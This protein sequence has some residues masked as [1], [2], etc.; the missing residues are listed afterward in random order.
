[1]TH[2]LT[3]ADFFSLHALGL[4]NSKAFSLG[5]FPKV[6]ICSQQAS[7]ILFPTSFKY[8]PFHFS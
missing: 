3:W 8:V 1:M 7:N 2:S 6:F 4:L 5:N